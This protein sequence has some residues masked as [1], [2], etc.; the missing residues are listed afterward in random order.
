LG[1]FFRAL[2]T[3]FFVLFFIFAPRDN[4]PGDYMP[5]RLVRPNS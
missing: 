1:G 5:V 2:D 4:P 3:I